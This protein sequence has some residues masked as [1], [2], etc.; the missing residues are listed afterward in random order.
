MQDTVPADL[1]YTKD[2]E[3]ARR[4]GDD[5]IVIGITA[6]AVDQLGDITMLTLPEVGDAVTAHERAG[7]IDS[8]KAVSEL[9]SPVSGEVVEVNGALADAPETVN[10][11]PYGAGWMIKI[12][13]SDPGQLG[14]LLSA[15]AYNAYLA[16][17]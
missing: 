10:Q 3:W 7:D 16:E 12:R 14:E 5:T 9:F 8:V 1:L 2:H 15:D 6:H 13:L 17:G 4:E 11:D